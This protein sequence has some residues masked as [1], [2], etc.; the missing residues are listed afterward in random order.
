MSPIKFVLVSVILILASCAKPFYNEQWQATSVTADGNAR[1]WPVPLG[2]YDGE[3]KLQYTYSNDLNN[4]YL[5]MKVVDE[6]TQVKIIRAGLQLWIDTIGRNR[7]QTG[8]FFPMGNPD[9][10]GSDSKNADSPSVNSG[11]EDGSTRRRGGDHKTDI[12]SLKRKFFAAPKEMQ[13]TGFKPPL[14]GL[15]SMENNNDIKISI[16]WDSTNTLVYE[17]VIPFKTFYKKTL[18]LS[19]TTKILGITVTIN[20]LTAP[21]GHGGGGGGMGGG[22]MGGGGMGGGGMGG[23][24]MGGGG[25]GGKGGGGGRSAGEANPLYETNTLKTQ[26][27][28]STSAGKPRPASMGVW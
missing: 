13:L 14:G 5:C 1:E 27:K 12:A 7:H 24:G 16:N 8:I 26:L 20:G 9:A 10:A 25:R 3:T 15:T 22:G 19:D 18:S 28:L 2:F 6:K 17:A 23:G 21:A 11:T 4:L